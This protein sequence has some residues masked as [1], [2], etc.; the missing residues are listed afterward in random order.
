[1]NKLI[2]AGSR[3]FDDYSL[4]HKTMFF[5]YNIECLEI[6]CGGARGADRLGEMF[7]KDLKLPIKYFPANWNKYGKSAGYVRNKQ[8]GEYADLAIVFWDGQ[9][10]GTQHMINIMHELHKPVRIIKYKEGDLE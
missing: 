4:L 5:Y 10:K 7:A 6:V 3:D 1:M 8:M 9:S 2:I